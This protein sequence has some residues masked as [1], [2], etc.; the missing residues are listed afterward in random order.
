MSD[1]EWYLREAR[2]YC[3]T[4]YNEELRQRTLAFLENYKKNPQF[5]GL[6]IMVLRLNLIKQLSYRSIWCI[7][8]YSP[9]EFEASGG[10]YYDKSSKRTIFFNSIEEALNYPYFKGKSVYEVLTDNN[11]CTE[12]KFHGHYSELK[13]TD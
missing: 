4:K 11:T 5:G 10:D 9:G 3:G 6:Y 7:S 2:H 1:R 13:N 12:V 8:R